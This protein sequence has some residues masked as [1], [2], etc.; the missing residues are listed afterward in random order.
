[1]K[2]GHVDHKQITNYVRIE[3]NKQTTNILLTSINSF[4]TYSNMQSL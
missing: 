3:L 2:L 1:M 4:Y